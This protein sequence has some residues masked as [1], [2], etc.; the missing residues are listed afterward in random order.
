MPGMPGE[1]ADNEEN[2][3]PPEEQ[4]LTDAMKRLSDILRE[5][6]EL[7]D[8]TLAQ[9]RGE[10]PGQDQQGQE[11]QESG[12][13]GQQQGG[14]H[15]ADV[16]DQLGEQQS[17]EQGQ[18]GN[19]PGSGEQAGEET[20]GNG[21]GSQ[22]AENNEDGEGSGARPGETLAERQARLGEL[23]ERF[24]REKG[25]GEGAGE[26]ALEGKIDPDAL[27]GIRQAQRRAEQALNRGDESSA[28][29]N[30]QRATQLLSD[31][32]RGLASDLDELQE[33]RTGE[34]N[35]AGAEDPFGRP[36]NGAGNNGDDIRVPDATERQR[37]KDILEELRRRYGEAEDEEEREYLRRLLDR[38]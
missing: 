29:R 38:F 10:T 37:A 12:Q 11:G 1:Q 23:V 4:E 18:E 15:M 34:Q 24:A 3:L 35:N 17:G 14:Q 31:V 21:G 20:Q 19:Q 32:A 6:R 7:N 9:Q 16:L 30:Q 36:S 28:A 27:N 22:Q 8:D 25:L 5:Q 26:N 2:D 33:A 13:Q